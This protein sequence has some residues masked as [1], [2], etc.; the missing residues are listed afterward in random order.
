MIKSIQ[1][2][3][4]FGRFNYNISM[5]SGG[6]TII[7][8]PN[9]F[10][11]STILRI[12]NALNSENIEFFMDLDFSKIMIVF[13]NEKKA[14]IQKTGKNL[15]VNNASI[16]L[17]D[18]DQ[19]RF[20]QRRSQAQQRNTSSPNR[21]DIVDYE[22][23]YS[24]TLD[25]YRYAPSLSTKPKDFQAFCGLQKEFK[26]IKGWCGDVRFISDQRLIREAKRRSGPDRGRE[27]VDVIQELPNRLK[28]EISKVSE[29]YS[30]IANT[31]DG[32]YP[33]RL[34]A[35][36]TGIRNQ[37]EYEARLREANEKFKKLRKYDL[38]EL[39]MIKGETYNESYSTALNTVII[40]EGEDDIS[41]F[42]GKLSSNVDIRESFSG[43]RGVLEIVSLFSDSRV[44]GVCDVDYDTGT[45][46]PQILYYDYSCLEMMLISSDSAFTPFFHTYY[47]GKAG[48]AEIRLKLLQELK[49]L[50]CYRKLNS[51]FGWAICFN[52]LSM[53]KAFETETQNINT[54]KI[55]S[56]IRELNPSLTEHIRRQVD[57]VHIEYDKKHDLPELLSITQGHDFLD[58]FRELCSTTWPK[59]G[60]FPSSRE[61]SRALVTS[62][63][64]DDF[65]RTVLYQQLDSYQN[66]YHLKILPA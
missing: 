51:I 33:T 60:K 17:L 52:G 39:P 64:Q 36:R 35:T 34:F 43:K 27:I 62:F 54:A 50:S 26:Q 9:G 21:N 8:G 32:S 3:K 42:N 28:G 15:S 1:L 45:P 65:K 24:V 2:H 10:G 53:K 48:F 59:C 19:L 38:V 57:Q 7:T 16:P 14:F 31:L 30:R 18:K 44:I 20:F 58:Y 5:K 63:R 12:I 49:W 29:E 47:R 13:D 4:L 56:Q 66:A 40:V 41:F 6:V 23:L 61:L 11:K 37:A 55:I 46:S 25:D 22:M